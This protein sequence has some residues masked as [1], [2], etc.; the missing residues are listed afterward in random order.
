VPRFKNH[1]KFAILLFLLLCVIGIWSMGQFF[2]NIFSPY[3][4]VYGAIFC[5]AVILLSF[6]MRWAERDI[7]EERERMKTS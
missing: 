1:P 4:Y 2:S 3:T 7:L 6:L 5:V